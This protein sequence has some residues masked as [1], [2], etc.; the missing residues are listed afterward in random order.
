MAFQRKR[1]TAEN[2]QMRLENMCARSEHCEYEL[3]EKLRGWNVTPSDADAIL[4]SM[5][6]ARFYDDERFAE[7]FVRDKLLYNRW[8][9]RR[10]SIGLRSKRI[11][12]NIIED[13]LATIDD[14]EYEDILRNL[15][16]AKARTI[17]EGNTYEGRTKLYRFALARGFESSL[18]SNLIREGLFP[19]TGGSE[20]QY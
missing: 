15:L 14:D 16:K 9:K 17:K 2:A 18:I 20:S 8:G 7:A 12:S 5:R 19:E 6:K 1:I 3:R 4:A 10:I 13:S 11:D